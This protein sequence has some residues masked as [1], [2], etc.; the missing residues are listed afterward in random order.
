[1]NAT[2][3]AISAL[4]EYDPFGGVLRA[5]GPVAKINPLRFSTKYQDDETGL[6]YYGYRYYHP[7]TG[8]WL[9]R[10]PVGE[11][12]GPNLYGFVNNSSIGSF[13]YLGC[14]QEAG[15]FYSV[16][17]VAIAK[18]YSSREAYRLAYFSQ[19]PDEINEYS[20]WEGLGKWV[21]DR[22][23]D[24][25]WIHDIQQVLHSLH[26]GD[27]EKRRECLQKIAT[28]LS[29]KPSERGLVLHALGDS[30]AHTKIDTKTGKLVAYNY[31]YG[32]GDE[33]YNGN[34][35]DLPSLRPQLYSEYIN[36]LFLSLPS[37]PGSQNIGLVRLI[38]EKNEEL[39]KNPNPMMAQME[40]I[41]FII[42]KSDYPNRYRP[43][44]G[45]YDSNHPNG[46]DDLGPLNHNH[47]QN[48]IDLI[49]KT[50]CKK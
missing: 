46:R 39:A 6:D 34:A 35:P 21:G 42:E 13:D 11:A 2:T 15:H 27:V 7:D 1:M 32:H 19:L 41:S 10:D 24:N 3:G 47:V 23:F 14:Y 36:S 4:Y 45:N 38:S 50:C 37:G 17:A 9:S 49:K 8:R 44:L 20:A 16:Y 29:L 31:P 26:G 33:P 30:Y 5:T 28:N 25:Q 18:G 40:L 48:L 22:A 43:E 12:G